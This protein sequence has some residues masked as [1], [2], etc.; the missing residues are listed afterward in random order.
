MDDLKK[1]VKE[2]LEKKSESGYLLSSVEGIRLRLANFLIYLDEVNMNQWEL[3]DR[4]VIESFLMFLKT[5]KNYSVVTVNG[6]RKWIKNFFNYLE[7]KK[8]IDKNPFAKEKVSYPEEFEKSMDEYIKMKEFENTPYN[9]MKKIKLSLKLFYSFLTE[10]EITKHS[11]V[12]KEDL[13]NFIKH[14]VDLTDKK[15]NAIY[16]TT[17]VNRMLSGLKPYIQ[18]LSKKGVFV[19]GF[20]ANLIYLKK[21]QRLS[22]NILNRKELVALFSLKVFSLYEFMMKSI[23]IIQYASGLRISEVLSLE[24]K[25]IDFT[26]CTVKIF[27]TKTNKERTVQLGEVGTKYLKLLTE[28]VRPRVCYD[29]L[30]SGKVFLSYQ[31]GKDLNE[32]T[33]NCYLKMFCEKTGIKKKVTT[34]CFRHSYGSHLLENGLGIKE[35]SD[36]MGHKDLTATEQYTRLNPE[37]LRKTINNCHPLEMDFVRLHK[38]E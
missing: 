34:H 17:S 23:C 3:I 5:T 29:Y 19:T 21:I 9:S 27:E 24:M 30:K 4:E 26:S 7:E 25:D 2:Y 10:R 15:G 11:E 28:K 31:E 8:R 38:E 14:L 36:L 35:V 1:L 32:N 37:R 12:K 20:S 13:T 33:V 22:R 16:Q 6:Y 18:W